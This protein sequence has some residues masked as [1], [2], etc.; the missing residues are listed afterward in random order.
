MPVARNPSFACAYTRSSGGRSVQAL[1]D[2][3]DALASADAHRDQSVATAA[4]FE[5][6]QRLHGQ[7]RSGCTDWV[8][9]SDGAAGVGRGFDY[10]VTYPGY[11]EVRHSL[12]LS[13]LNVQVIGGHVQ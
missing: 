13:D 10:A 5:L 3:R 7:D 9:E 2:G 1:E 4:T 6:V 11:S 12:A 8:T